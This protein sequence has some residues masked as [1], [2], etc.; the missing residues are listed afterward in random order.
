MGAA[1]MADKG[2]WMRCYDGTEM[3][4]EFIG[5]DELL[6]LFESG[7]DN[8]TIAL[9]FGGRLM[10]DVDKVLNEKRK[11]WKESLKS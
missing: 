2:V 10:K 7:L 11:Q 6:P 3:E 1:Q 5:D 4:Y 8:N 9:T